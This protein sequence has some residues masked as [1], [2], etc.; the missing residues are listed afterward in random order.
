MR[1]V[2]DTNIYVSG[3]ILTHGTPFEILEA[4]WR[5]TY[6]L[7]TSEATIE[8]IERVLRYPHIRDRYTVNE[9]DIVRLAESLRADGLVVRG[10]CEVSGV[11]FDPDADMFLACALEGRV[12]CIVAG[13]LDLLGLVRYQGVD[14]LKPHQ[15]L[16]RL[17]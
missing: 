10:F 9:Q 1:A 14:M 12:D 13:D 7:V 8:E 5:R 11:S 3:T 4:W 16:E 2:L 6:I 15:F 17:R